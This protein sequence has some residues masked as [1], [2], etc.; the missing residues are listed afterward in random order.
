[1]AFNKFLNIKG[2]FIILSSI[3][4]VIITLAYT[5]NN[6]KH[7]KDIIN[8]KK[9]LELYNIKVSI[10]HQVD[11]LKGVLI[12]LSNT[13]MTDKID[14]KKIQKYF[15]K[16][17]KSTGL[18]Y[19]IIITDTKGNLIV[20]AV[21][22]KGIK[23]P[24][25]RLYF[26]RALTE[27]DFVWGEFA[28][29]RTTGK[30]VI[31]F[32][33]P[34]LD[35]NRNVKYIIIAVPMIDRVLP[36]I[37][38][39]SNKGIRLLD[40]NGIIVK[41]PIENEE[42]KKYVYFEDIKKGQEIIEKE[43]NNYIFTA[44]ITYNDKT[45]CYIVKEQ[46][47]KILPILNEEGFFKNIGVFLLISI[48][49][50]S[51]TL[52][53]FNKYI[54][55][56]LMNLEQTFMNFD[57]NHE[58]SLPK[59]TFLFKELYNLRNSFIK[60]VDKIKEQH[61]EI[62]IEKNLWQNTF[63]AV[64]EPFFIV[65]QEFRIIKANDSFIKTFNLDP[66]NLQNY[67]CYEVVHKSEGIV[68]SCPY[69]DILNKKYS[70]TIESYFSE[71]NKYFLM[72][73]N[74]IIEN[75]K[76]IGFVHYLKDI[77]ALKVAE[78]KRINMERQLL[79]T[80]KLES[81]GILAGGVAHDF[82][83][84]LMGILGNI[85]LALLDKDKLP[86]NVIHNLEVIKNASEKASY[87]TKQ[88]L[89]YSGKGKFI[90]QEIDLNKFIRDIFELL[91]VS[92]SKKATIC[93]NLK[94]DEDLIINGDPGQIEQVILNLVIN[95]SEALEDKVGLITIS[96]GK[97]YCDKAYLENTFSGGVSNLKEGE[98]VFL[99][100]TDTGCGMDKETMSRIFEPFFT[101]KFTGRGLGLSAI[102]GI[103]RGHNGAIRV[104]SEKGKG[105]SFKVLFPAGTKSEKRATINPTFVPTLKGATILIV[106]DENLVLEVASQMIKLLGGKT[107]LANDGREGI[108]KFKENKDKI[109]FVLLDLTMPDLSGDE[110][111]RE[112][113]KIK[114]D[115]K[116]ILMSGYNDQEVSQ[117]LVGRGFAG[118]IQKPFTLDSLQKIFNKNYE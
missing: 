92:I 80:Q 84:I 47:I 22:T 7:V 4:F 3:S 115:V 69:Q 88:L 34:V 72:T 87:L 29:S 43:D 65:D 111:F 95:A 15:E 103:V 21:P 108:T 114:E 33:M 26:K 18:F 56:P 105:S 82:N 51:L 99:E 27:K 39:S 96:T 104:Y 100:V 91:K 94:E 106:D 42:G 23:P 93:L 101:T 16:V 75:D 24:T 107:I 52:F 97:I 41:S 98:Y 5:Y 50:L 45:L 49:G 6:F 78:E 102:L 74:P 9:A 19:N 70:Y 37:S 109:D 11:S 46:K 63:N 36:I 14:T 54:I 12:T 38:A 60:L 86:E 55:K 1:M 68:S 57:I 67:R 110:V 10:E 28:I 85:E 90:I 81:L 66:N 8:D 20:S 59:E 13:I 118:F 64:Q 112:I 31:H 58:L 40:E 113:K 83:N 35:E 53:I 89:A 76:V 61:H 73:F 48:L 62:E 79:Q 25:D 32:A 30:K 44:K 71:L 77:T 117:R 17:M 2:F 116:V